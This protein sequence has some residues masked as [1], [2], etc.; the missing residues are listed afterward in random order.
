MK[1]C[2]CCGFKT[3]KIK[4]LKTCPKCGEASWKMPAPRA[5]AERVEPPAPASEPAQ[6]EAA[7]STDG[8]ERLEPALDP[9]ERDTAPPPESISEPASSDG[10]DEPPESVGETDG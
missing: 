8:A 9:A 5:E 6:A 4:T 3:R 2:L 10:A 1:T 7:P